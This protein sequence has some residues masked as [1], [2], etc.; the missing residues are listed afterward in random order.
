MARR[1]RA[2]P[3]PASFSLRVQPALR[4]NMPRAQALRYI[5]G[6]S[7]P[8]EQIDYHVA[9][10]GLYARDGRYGDVYCCAEVD[11]ATF[12]NFRRRR[13]SRVQFLHAL[14]VKFGVTTNL[15]RRRLQYRRCERT[16]L[17]HLWLF[18]FRTRNRY[19]LEHL[20]HLGFKCEA[21]ADRRLCPSCGTTHCEYW[22]FAD[23][24]SSFRALVTQFRAFATA[25]GEPVRMRRLTDYRV[26]FP[27][28]RS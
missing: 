13:I 20:S 11:A 23:L 15:P 9:N 21:P 4:L 6:R 24:G 7:T 16:G 19:R 12:R 5:R 28:R 17:V 18:A 27:K 26:A 25:I 22:K 8:E 2:A 14:R 1:S 10:P 3:A